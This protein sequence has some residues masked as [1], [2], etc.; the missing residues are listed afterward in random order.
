MCNRCTNPWDYPTQAASCWVNT[1]IGDRRSVACT[2]KRWAGHFSGTVGRPTLLNRRLFSYSFSAVFPCHCANAMYS[3]GEDSNILAGSQQKK[4]ENKARNS[5]T[6]GNNKAIAIQVEVRLIKK[7]IFFICGSTCTAIAFY[8]SAPLFPR[9]S[10]LPVPLFFHF[11]PA[12]GLPPPFI[13]W[14]Q[15]FSPLLYRICTRAKKNGGKSVPI[16]SAISQSL[17]PVYSL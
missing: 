9:S 11:L 1:W 17:S 5:K 14:S 8:I 3:I 12:G 6:G 10:F 4:K 16:Q 15:P 2:S 7:N 13:M